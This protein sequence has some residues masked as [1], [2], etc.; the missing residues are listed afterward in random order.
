MFIAALFVKTLTGN[1][2]KSINIII[3]KLWYIHMEYSSMK[4]WNAIVIDLW[5][6]QGLGM[7][8]P[9]EVKIESTAKI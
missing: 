1:N 8:V 7:L 5:T 4:K 3:D 6:M 2:L 9:H